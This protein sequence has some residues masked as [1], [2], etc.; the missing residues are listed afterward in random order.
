[1]LQPYTMGAS[2]RRR[3]LRQQQNNRCA[4]HTKLPCGG[5]ACQRIGRLLRSNHQRGVRCTARR[6]E[7]VLQ[8]RLELH[9]LTAL[10][11]SLVSLNFDDAARTTVTLLNAGKL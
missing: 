9:R 7:R 10:S 1:M 8:D 4:K 6:L 3:G 11:R 2:R 5:A